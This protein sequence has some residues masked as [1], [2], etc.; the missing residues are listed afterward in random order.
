MTSRSLLLLYLLVLLAWAWPAHAARSF[1]NCTGFI[2]SVPAVI[3]TPGTWCLNQ[4]VSTSIASGDAIT[5]AADN[6]VVDCNDFALDGSSAGSATTAIGIFASDRMGDTVRHC[7]I[8]GFYRGLLMQGTGGSHV[9]E[10]NHFDQNVYNGLRIEG[11]SSIVRRNEILDTGG[12]NSGAAYGIVS[13]GTNDIVGNIV[14]GVAAV[15]GDSGSGAAYGILAS[16]DLPGSRISNNRVGG[17]AGDPS[18]AGSYG[19]RTGPGQRMAL[20]DNVVVGDNG[21]D[22]REAVDCSADSTDNSGLLERA[23]DN[24]AKGFTINFA[25]CGNAGNNDISSP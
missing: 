23:K 18:G 15:A 21:T 10:D 3:S 1:D 4:N 5:I 11:E 16:P 9:I 20:R 12:S 24:V 7:R 22:T 13:V 2:N 14:Q 19:I 25:N 8:R 6:V 17:L